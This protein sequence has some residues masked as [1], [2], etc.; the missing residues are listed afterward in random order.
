MTEAMRPGEELVAMGLRD[1]RAERETVH[2]LLVVIGASR[3]RRA[4]HDVRVPARWRRDA[5][6]ALYRML[7][8]EWGDEAHL[9]YNALTRQ[10]VS[11]CEAQTAA[12]G[13]DVA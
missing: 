1:L 12:A 3:L 11:Y 10:L 9:R 13:A 4:G 7:Q 2:A 8:A 5:E 6:L